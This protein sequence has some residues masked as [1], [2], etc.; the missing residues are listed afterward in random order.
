MS[1]RRRGP[2]PRSV[3]KA[4]KKVAGPATD[5]VPPD[6]AEPTTYS[7]PPCFMHELDDVDRGDLPMKDWAEIRVWRRKQRE[8]LLDARLAIRSHIRT[9]WSTA[10]TERAV[11]VLPALEGHLVG[12]YWPFKGEYDPRQLV[13]ELCAR[14]VRMAL[15][16]VVRK[17]APLEFCTWRP[18]DKI[19]LGVWNIPVSAEGAVVQPDSLLVPLLGFDRHGYRLGYGGGYYDRTL[20]AMADRPL[21]IGLGFEQ[22]LLPTIHPQPHDVPMDLIITEQRTR[23][24]SAR[25]SQAWSAARENA[26]Q[27]V[28]WRCLWSR[29]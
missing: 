17:A 8:T 1:D 19:T 4:E 18:G 27:S 3:P 21:L 6:A 25:G 15:P 28:G 9:L 14:D 16:A 5:D 13:Q 7:S 11:E 24:V 20:G 23:C 10:L 22:A 26:G 12:I 29:A 2:V